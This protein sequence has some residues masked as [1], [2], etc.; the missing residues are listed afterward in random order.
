[1][2]W[3]TIQGQWKQLAGK[4]REKWGAF[5]DDE[6]EQI[7]GKKDQLVGKLQERYGYAKDRAEQEADEFTRSLSA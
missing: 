4:V 6:I 1:M 3:D 5:T 2:N 7:A